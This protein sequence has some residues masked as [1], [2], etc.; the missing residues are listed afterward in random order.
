MSAALVAGA[1]LGNLG[2]NLMP[3]LLPGMAHRFHLSSSVVGLVATIQLL[4]TAMAT[5]ALTSR[6]AR[7]G[8]ARIARWGLVATVAGFALAA[9]APNLTALICANILAGLG[10]G[11]VN[12]TA[13]AAIA[14]TGDTDKASTVAVLGGTVT[15][16][17]LVLIVPAVNGAEGSAAGFA[18]LTACCLPVFWLLRALPDAA[19]PEHGEVTQTPLPVFFLLA[20]AMLGATD[21]GAWSY[22]G[23]LGEDYAGMSSSAVS[24]V[25]A[26]ASIVALVGV[27]LSR[28]A[29]RRLGRLVALGV[30]LAVEAFTKLAIAAVPDGSVFTAAA[31]LWQVCYMGVLVSVLAV[32]AAADGSGRWVAASSGALAIGAGLGPAAAGWVLDS[33]GP[34]A[35]GVV[36]AVATAAAAIPVLRTCRTAERTP[37]QVLQLAPQT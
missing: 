6:V 33:W 1:T 26:V 36:L 8:R 24:T 23:V 30:F 3:V 29:A 7:P 18:L 5:L 12:A 34:V 11:V 22:S 35:L 19:E 20:L 9:V 10:L 14:A 2:A 21:Q 32:A 37:G 28:P 4:T 27:A 25:L 15:L 17:L 16:A 13:M 31:I